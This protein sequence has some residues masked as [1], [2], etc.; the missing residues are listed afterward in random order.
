MPDQEVHRFGQ[1]YQQ[2]FLMTSGGEMISK[3]KWI[4]LGAC[5]AAGMLAVVRASEVCTITGEIID[6]ATG[7]KLA[8]V[9]VIL[10]TMQGGMPRGIRT[11][12]DGKYTFSMVYPPG[13][14]KITVSLQGYNTVEQ[15]DVW[16]AIN[17][18][19][20]VIPPLGLDRATGPATTLTVEGK[21]AVVNTSDAARKW[22]VDERTVSTLPLSGVRTFDVLAFLAPGVAQVPQ[23]AG[24]GPGVGPG[25]GTAGQ[26]SVNGQR[27]R[28]NNF[29]VDM[30]DNN[31]Q[32][33]GVRRQW[34]VSLVPQS[35]ESIEQ[36]QVITGFYQAEFGRNSGSIVNVVSK[37]GGNALHGSIYGYLNQQNLNARNPFDQM[38]GPAPGKSPARR[39]QFGIAAGGPFVPDR[40]FWFGSFERQRIKD[41]P[42]RHFA[43]PGADERTYFGVSPLRP[44]ATPGVSELE[45]YFANAGYYLPGTAGAAV[46][47]LFPLPNNPGGPYGIN[48]YTEQMNGDGAGS[49]FSLKTDH[50]FSSAHS[51]TGRYNFTDDGLNIP[52]TGSGI[53][54][55]IKPETRTQNLS[56]F[57]NSIFSSRT[58]N[59]LRVSYGRTNLDFQEVAGSPL[60]FGSTN[61]SELL[62]LFPGNDSVRRA[63][64][65]P[66]QANFGRGTYGP[67]GSTG[68]LGQLLI[69]PYS[70]LGVDVYNF[71]QA[72][73]NN[74]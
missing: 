36:F 30:S 27:G 23:S 37:T 35:I 38:D 64:T 26:Y 7:N 45:R 61:T 49:I 53:H 69:R 65:T 67:F 6:K 40:S 25:V 15:T 73:I 66:I 56:L 34:Y 42:E 12:A 22:T 51:F 46:W 47:S 28:Q 5:L 44:S 4:I 2:S 3:F 55:S 17:D 19:K 31:D 60:L 57:L 33:V 63:L 10:T 71:P 32:D 54:S 43:V 68:A 72:R 8:N 41:R 70:P 50:K 21:A 52:V 11:D 58:A 16:L 74:T 9:D 39:S 29:L 14:Y 24:S 20:I 18:T 1:S 13:K 59:Q 62:A 48:T